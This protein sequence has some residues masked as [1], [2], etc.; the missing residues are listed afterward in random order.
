MIDLVTIFV[1]LSSFLLELA[2]KHEF[3]M[4]CHSFQ[5]A[6]EKRYQSV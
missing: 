1:S 4:Q 5:G 2:A 3:A 6:N